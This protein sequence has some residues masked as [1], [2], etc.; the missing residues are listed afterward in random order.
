MSMLH[1]D[2]NPHVL[3]PSAAYALTLEDYVERTL[4]HL[5]GRRDLEESIRHIAS[6]DN[7]KDVF[8]F[9]LGELELAVPVPNKHPSDVTEQGINEF[10]DGVIEEFD[11][12]H[13]DDLLY[14]K[15][16]ELLECFPY[17]ITIKAIRA[18]GDDFGEKIRA[19]LRFIMNKKKGSLADSGFK[20]F[21][22]DFGQDTDSKQVEKRRIIGP[23]MIEGILNRRIDDVDL[24]FLEEGE[25]FQAFRVRIRREG[26]VGVKW[27]YTDLV[28]KVMKDITH[29]KNKKAPLGSFEDE[30]RLVL[31]EFGRD[32]VPDTLFR[33]HGVDTP[34]IAKFGLNQALIFQEYI[35]G[36][37]IFQACRDPF[38]AGHLADILPTYVRLYDKMMTTRKKV[39]DCVSTRAEDAL[40]RRRLNNRQKD[41]LQICIIDTNN[42]HDVGSKRYERLLGGN[43]SNAYLE[44]LRN[45]IKQRTLG[46]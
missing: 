35:N 21:I 15:L 29:D 43:G 31:G 11:G 23:E 18:R 27:D 40:V 2:T 26:K 28:I 9:I 32:F 37:S 22:S 38:L 44:E 39:I 6:D 5:H 3:T 10:I 45:I 19:L 16:K 24:V 13:K 46:A 17:E 7:A 41:T 8:D 42:L 12:F 34:L 4:V 1:L 20:N 33:G 25:R 36:L 30:H 14:T